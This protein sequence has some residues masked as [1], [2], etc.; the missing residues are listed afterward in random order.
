MMKVILKSDVPNL[1]DEGDIVK[2]APGYFRNFLSPRGMAV[3]GT[4]SGLKELEFK[5]KRLEKIKAERRS[6]AQGLAAK[7]GGKEVVV[8]Q[9]CGEKGQLFGSVTNAAIAEALK[10]VGYDVDRRKI[11][12]TSPIKTIG[13]FNVSLRIY[14]GVDVTIKVHVKPEVD[15][16]EE[17]M[18]GLER[19]KREAA[20]MERIAKA[21][22]EAAN[23]PAAAEGA[24]A[25]GA[26]AGEAK[27]AAG[28][29][30]AEAKP[31]KKEKK[32]DAGAGP[33]PSPARK[34]K[35]KE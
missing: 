8:R 5:K 15:Q 28:E 1:G 7:I 31:A 25:E 4:P 20:E 16:E 2:V 35:K 34:T 18:K 3:L 9:R 24:P 30:E 12:I 22:Q 26:E 29:G 13:D 19:A 21:A 23:A 6:E 33:K 11:H 14:T 32:D 27:V 10:G 17:I